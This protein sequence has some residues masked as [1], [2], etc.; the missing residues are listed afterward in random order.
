MMIA[1]GNLTD[2]E[3]KEHHLHTCPSCCIQIDVKHLSNVL[4]DILFVAFHL[5]FQLIPLRSWPTFSHL[6]GLGE[7]ECFHSCMGVLS[8][9]ASMKTGTCFFVSAAF[10]AEPQP[11]QLVM[12]PANKQDNN[13]HL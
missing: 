12:H 9:P 7:H 13:L 8:I 2:V 4:V 10:Y 11:I 3:D 5:R 6:P 1:V